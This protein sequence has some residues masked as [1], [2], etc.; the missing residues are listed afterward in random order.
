VVARP[1]PKRDTGFLFLVGQ[2]FSLPRPLGRLKACPTKKRLCVPILVGLAVGCAALR[3]P[4]VL[5]GRPAPVPAD[6]AGPLRLETAFAKALANVEVVQAAVAVRTAGVGR[7]EALKSFVPLMNLPQLAVGV[8]RLGGPEGGRSV[9]FPDVTGGTPF[10]GGP[11]Q[12]VNAE[13]NRL[14]LFLPL[15]PAGQIAALPLAEEGI[16]AKELMEQLVRRSQAVLAAQRYFEAKQ[17]P[18][19][20][21]TAERGVRFS[22]DNLAVTERR[23][24]EKQAFD[25]EVTEA[26]VDVGRAEVLAAELAKEFD[27]RR[28]RLGVVLHTSRLLATQDEGPLP[29]TAEAGYAFDLDDPDA[30]DLGLI[31]DLPACREDAIALAKQQRVEVRIMEVGLRAARLQDQKDLLSLLGFGRLPLGLSFKNTTPG[32]GGIA[33][34]AIFGTLYDVPLVDIGLWAGLRKS[35]LDVVRSQLDLEKALVDVS[36]DAGDSWDRWQFAER[37][38]RQR[39]DEYRLRQDALTRQRQLLAEKQAIPVDVLAAEVAASQADA[40]RWTAWYT[41]QL[42]R[43]DVLRS[44]ELLLDYVGKAKGATQAGPSPARPPTA[45]PAPRPEETP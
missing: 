14:N 23:F 38:W 29:V 27:V 8:H 10:V 34:G 19:G 35:R 12:P 9:I 15:D 17:V 43:L 32:N 45:L 26:R 5:P 22:R 13:L 24:A 39:E 37:Q 40:N 41:L 25:L 16:R 7:F 36:A 44:T 21:I 30:V 2:A 6:D 4:E 11:G 3:P 18:Y 28:R 20:L 42:A 33:L 1:P 31:P